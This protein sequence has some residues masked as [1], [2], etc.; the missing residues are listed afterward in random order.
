MDVQRLTD[1]MT[2]DFS[3]QAQSVQDTD[4]YDIRLHM[5][6]IWTNDKAANW[7]YVEQAV[8]S[9]ED[10]PYRQRVYKVTKGDDGVFESA[11]F[12][13]PDEKSYA[14][15][16]KNTDI[17]KKIKPAD[18]SERTG[19]TVFLKKMADGSFKGATHKSDCESALRGASYATSKVEVHTDRL[20][21]WD[22]GF[23][24]EGKQVWGAEKGGYV[25][26]KQQ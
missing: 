9:A 19:C 13:L 3:S 10:R 12:T 4:Y 24:A 14:G 5:R 8:A 16:W 6:P 11:V 23:D 18:L 2:G 7:L 20:E 25:F 21:S 26:M 1:M 22:Q 15:A 17:F